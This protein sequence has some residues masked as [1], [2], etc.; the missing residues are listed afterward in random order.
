MHTS[1]PFA[2]DVEGSFYGQTQPVATLTVYSP[3]TRMS[4]AVRC[5][6]RTAAVRCTGANGILVSF[7]DGGPHASYC[8]AGYCATVSCPPGK[9]SDDWICQTSP[10]PVARKAVGQAAP[11]TSTAPSTSPTPDCDNNSYTGTF[12]QSAN[13]GFGGCQYTFSNGEQVTAPPDTVLVLVTRGPTGCGDFYWS[14]R[15]SNYA[16]ACSSRLTLPTVAGQG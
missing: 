8:S 3:L 5:A 16:P 11:T 1:C 13:N 4:Y 6:L 7:D 10:N 2:E 14:D 15:T 9:A 12:D